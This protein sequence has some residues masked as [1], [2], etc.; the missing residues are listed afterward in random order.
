MIK[1][2]EKPRQRFFDTSK[3]LGEIRNDRDGCKIRNV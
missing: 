1:M 3:L 2:R